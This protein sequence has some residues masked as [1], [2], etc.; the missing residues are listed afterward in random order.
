[1][2]SGQLVPLNNN[3]NHVPS[4]YTLSGPAT[5]CLIDGRAD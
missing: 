4:N 3:H 5:W 2:N 1:V